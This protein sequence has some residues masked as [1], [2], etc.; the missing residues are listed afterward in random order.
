[1]ALILDSVR[2][3]HASAENGAEGV[4]AMQTGAFEAVLMDI[5]MPVMDGLAAT[6]AIRRQEREMGRPMA[7]V[8]I[9]SA[10]CQPDQVEV[11]LLQ[12]VRQM[13]PASPCLGSGGF[14]FAFGLSPRGTTALFT[15]EHR[16]GFDAGLP[17]PAA[18]FEV[19]PFRSGCFRL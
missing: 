8:I 18:K 14:S 7:P 5:Q 12:S 19:N 3:E 11:P 9:V 17:S 10:S 13:Q 2:I 16:P 6:R 4:E 1:M 15:H